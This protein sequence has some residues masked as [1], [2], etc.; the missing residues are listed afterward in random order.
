MNRLR[1]FLF[2]LVLSLLTLAAFPSQEKEPT[3]IPVVDVIQPGV[4]VAAAPVDIEPLLQKALPVVD[5]FEQDYRKQFRAYAQVLWTYAVTPVDGKAELPT[6]LDANPT[7]QPWLKARALWDYSGLLAWPA[8]VRVD[9]YDGP[10]GVGYVIVLE[11]EFDKAHYQRAVNVGPEKWRNQ[12][13][14]EMKGETP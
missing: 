9:V 14:F 12:D 10:D 3:P 6:L 7:D 4:D 2:G 11:A 13:W 8:N 5:A 1:L